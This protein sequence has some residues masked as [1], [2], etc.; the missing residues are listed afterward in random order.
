[1]LRLQPAHLLFTLLA[2]SACASD[3]KQTETADT[4]SGSAD[5]SADT[6]ADGSA[7]TAADATADGS[8]EGS[9]N[10]PAALAPDAPWP[11]F[12]ADSEQTGAASFTPTDD[13]S[14]PWVFETGK[15]I[16]SSPV[17]AA[18][19]T[20]Y[21]GSASRSLYAIAPDGTERWRFETGEIIDSAALL[22]DTGGLYF[23]SG[24]GNL[25]ALDAASGA[26]RWRFTADAPGPRASIINWFEGN[27]TLGP[28]GTLLAGNDNFFVYGLDRT[29]GTQRWR[30]P[31]P[32]QTW[33]AVA[34]DRT[35][36][37]YFVGNNNLTGLTGNL[38]SFDLTGRQKWV[39]RGRGTVAASPVVLPH[40][41]V[42]AGAFDGY[43]RAFDALSGREQ[44]SFATR[45]HIYASPAYFAADDL[46]IQPSA[47]GTVYGID[48]TTGAQRW[49]FDWGSPIRSS[50]AVD[51]SGTSYVGTGDG[52]LLV[53]NRDGTL[54]WALKLINGDRDDLNASPALSP[55]GI[56][57]GGETGQVFFVPADYCIRPAAVPIEGCVTTAAE[58]LPS[59][60]T[61]L[62]F[63]AP[64]GNELRTGQPEVL[65]N[66]PITL[67]LSVRRDGD[68]RLAFLDPTSLT[69]TATPEAPFTLTVSP[70][71][72]HLTLTPDTGWQA[73]A[74]G[75]L[76][77]QLGGN[78]LEDPTRD[79]LQFSG[80][81]VAGQ[82]TKTQLLTLTTPP[83]EASVIVPTAAG[84]PAQRWVVERLA[85][86]LPTLMPSYNQIGFD[87]LW[88]TVT[89]VESNEAGLVTWFSSARRA[90][91]GTIEPD[92]A[93]GAA[94]PML[95]QTSGG[96]LTLQ[97]RGGMTLE[98]MS[99]TL[100]FAS[101]RI[102]AALDDSLRT[103]TTASVVAS[104]PCGSIELYGPFLRTL[105]LCN[106]DDDSL[107]ALGAANLR[108]VNAAGTIAGPGPIGEVQFARTATGIEAQLLTPSLV[109]ADHG[110]GLLII[111]AATGV[112]LSDPRLRAPTVTSDAAGNAEA[113]ALDAG[114]VALPASLRLWLMVDGYPAASTTL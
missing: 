45:D 15:G 66:Q 57:L 52:H 71:R 29:T 23:A 17:I 108:P 9:A 18:D 78:W 41:T 74:S 44:W 10:A 7:D 97:N 5:T 88:F 30:A 90:A 56:V 53:I 105:G 1:M 34:Y 73:D 8:A 111:D 37:R 75:L 54:R 4:G 19:G 84:T 22:D 86:P 28:D 50:P 65:A 35:T 87:S 2:L 62:I 82:W 99:A 63:T 91:D 114:P 27:V 79:G 94:F 16:F 46:L 47:D 80:G 93:S 33:S 64:F 58:P 36:G 98:V 43:L 38:F 112:P 104:G 77:L 72:R 110:F 85:V 81:T 25:Y 40:G 20:T 49:A 103:T 95:A 70:D 100:S 42:A 12:R 6:T 76:T 48:A 51:A 113:L 92:P 21:I 67:G 13:G 89:A 102:S 32:D 83:A 61:D 69:V 109:R 107:T 39:H 60:G 11:R 24:D 14:N 106:P 55:R 68:T 3:A 31:L 96:L 26:E 59:D 101:F